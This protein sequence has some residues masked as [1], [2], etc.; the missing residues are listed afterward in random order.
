M[1]PKNSLVDDLSLSDEEDV[2]AEEGQGVGG[3]GGGGDEE[4]G[5]RNP[6]DGGT[7]T[8]SSSLEFL[9]SDLQKSMKRRREETNGEV[10]RHHSE[11]KRL[12]S[13][14]GRRGDE[15]MKNKEQEVALESVKREGDKEE[16]DCEKEGEE[17]SLVSNLSLSDSEDENEEKYVG[18]DKKTGNGNAK[19]DAANSKKG[20]AWEDDGRWRSTVDKLRSIVKVRL[21]ICKGYSRE[22]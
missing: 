18:Q 13:I 15:V 1:P 7:T 10:T 8:R 2:G 3:G 16:R 11:R 12:R 9:D 5:P 21:H 19:N 14:F 4:E 6:S 20:E 22:N 17:N